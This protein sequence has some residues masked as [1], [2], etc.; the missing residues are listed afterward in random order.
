MLEIEVIEQKPVTIAE[1]K[2]LVENVKKEEQNFRMQKVSEYIN[3]IAAR[4]E[5]KEIYKKLEGLEIS[6]LRDRHIVK[7]IDLMPDNAD[8]LKA[9]FAGEVTSLKQD[10][11]QKILEAIN[12]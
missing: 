1:L 5:Q 11:I 7:I 10:E 3:G 12:G 4:K 6:K 2:G 9:I 8:S